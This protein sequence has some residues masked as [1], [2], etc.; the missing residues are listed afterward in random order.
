MLLSKSSAACSSSCWIAA[1]TRSVMSVL[2]VGALNLNIRPLAP[3]SDR[4]VARSGVAKYLEPKAPA[5]LSL[6]VKGESPL[7][8]PIAGSAWSASIGWVQWL[9][10]V[11]PSIG[12]RPEPAG[13]PVTSPI[14]SSRPNC[15]KVIAVKK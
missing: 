10:M 7:G 15:A 8:P 6:A 12:P 11:P 13:G 1:E 9:S 3:F 2:S 4:W 5:S 14:G